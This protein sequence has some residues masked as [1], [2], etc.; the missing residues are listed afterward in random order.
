[1][2]ELIEQSL[3]CGMKAVGFSGCTVFTMKSRPVFSI[4]AFSLTLYSLVGCSVLGESQ[5][6][7]DRARQ[8]E[9]RVNGAAVM[10]FDLD[11]TAHT[12]IKTTD[13]GDQSVTVRDPAEAGQLDLVR[14]HLRDIADEFSAGNFTDPTTI[15]GADMP[16]LATLQARPDSFTIVFTELSD[17]A[18]LEYR[19]VDPTIVAALHDWFD[20]QLADHGS[21]A[22]SDAMHSSGM[23]AELMC[24]HHPETC[25]E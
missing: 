5:Q 4:I 20:A 15:H 6:N 19:S 16:G 10:P 1:M 18:K 8:S 24:A 9:V 12:F 22:T 14:G 21:D 2:S 17:G 25:S 13:G 11:K 23:T 3:S 7:D